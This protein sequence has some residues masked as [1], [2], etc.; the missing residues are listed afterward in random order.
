MDLT[1]RSYDILMADDDKEDLELMEEAMRDLVDDLHFHKVQNGKS[2]LKYLES[3]TDK[4]LP[5]LIVLDYNM[6]E[7]TGSEVLHELNRKPR[8]KNI[9]KVVYSTS[10]APNHVKECKANGAADYFV[11]PTS[12]GDMKRIA[13]RLLAFC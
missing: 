11:K 5:C 3:K 1:K 6:P 8:Y 9:P 12:L 7:L 13:Q 10:N 2:A 4:E